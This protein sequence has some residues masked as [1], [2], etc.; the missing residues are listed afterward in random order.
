MAQNAL[1]SKNT[2]TFREILGVSLH[3]H[4]R[5]AVARHSLGAGW[6]PFCDHCNQLGSVIDCGSCGA[7]RAAQGF[8][9]DGAP[10]Y[11][12]TS[13]GQSTEPVPDDVAIA[14]TTGQPLAG[15]LEPKLPERVNDIPYE[16]L[17]LVLNAMGSSATP[18]T[19]PEAMKVI[20]DIR[21]RKLLLH[22]QRKT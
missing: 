2:R 7:T 16:T 13:T 3:T 6:C 5:R 12:A 1:S 19:R 14:L 8:D 10:V 11:Q 21:D 9:K 20:K 15:A 22:K 4:E 18:R 17:L